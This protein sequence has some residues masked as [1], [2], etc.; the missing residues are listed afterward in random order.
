[1]KLEEIQAQLKEAG[2]DYPT[3]SIQDSLKKINLTA[4]KVDE[5]FVANWIQQLKSE[6]ASAMTTKNSSNLAKA[7]AGGL[8]QQPPEEININASS[9]RVAGQ[10][11]DLAIAMISADENNLRQAAHIVAQYRQ[12]IP[13]RFVRQVDEETRA[14]MAQPAVVTQQ[15]SEWDAALD[16]I[17]SRVA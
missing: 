6:G 11:E 8:Q 14:L 2:L 13:S 3:K 1:M 7:N 15:Q 12:S 4:A 9:Q 16:R 17:R 5:A 10:V